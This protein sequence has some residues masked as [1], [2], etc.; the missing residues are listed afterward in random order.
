MGVTVSHLDGR[1]TI[2]CLSCAHTGFCIK[3]FR[4]G[5]FFGFSL[6]TMKIS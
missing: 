2:S 3:F 1:F 4:V 6:A 5:L